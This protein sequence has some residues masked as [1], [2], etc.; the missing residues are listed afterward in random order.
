[1]QVKGISLDQDIF[2]LNMHNLAAAVIWQ[3]CLDAKEGDLEAQRWLQGE[4]L[5]WLDALDLYVTP[6]TMA[7]WLVKGCPARI[8]K[9]SQPSFRMVQNV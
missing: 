7:T 6:E 5:I 4:G 1:L 9:Q 2:A 8:R 3:A